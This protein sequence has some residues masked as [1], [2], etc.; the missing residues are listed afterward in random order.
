LASGDDIRKLALVDPAD[1]P[2]IVTLSGSPPNAAMLSLTQ[3]N[4]AI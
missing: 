2:K 4:A 1:W 3:R